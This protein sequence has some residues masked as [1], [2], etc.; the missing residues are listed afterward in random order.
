M[1]KCVSVIIPSYN[2][3]HLLE[4]TIPSYLQED[5]GE[6]IIVDDASTDNTFAVVKKL[7]SKYQ[8]IKYVKMPVNSKQTIA[9]NEGIKHAKYSYIYFGDDDSFITNNTIKILLDCL[10]EMKA[11]VVGAKALYMDNASDYENIDAFISH[12]SKRFN[13]EKKINKYLDIL[14]LYH[15]SFDWDFDKP[16]KVPFCQACALVKKESI[17]NIRFDR[18]YGGNAF[19]EE[20]DFFTRISAAGFKIYYN[21]KAMQ[22]NLPRSTV[23]KGNSFIKYK[24]RAVIYEFINTYKYFKKNREFLNSYYSSFNNYKIVFLKY[25]FTALRIKS[26]KC[27]RILFK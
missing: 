6:V 19:R 25:L 1:S 17:R 24:I 4:K 20:T 3:A 11:D 26:I 16:I 14:N 5:V 12:K 9:K 10:I 7:Q 18:D 21:S 22:I 23:L 8:Q 2:R 13:S 15:I 27:I